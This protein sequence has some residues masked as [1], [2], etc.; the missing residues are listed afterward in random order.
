MSRAAAIESGLRPTPRGRAADQLI[1]LTAGSGGSGSVGG[2]APRS[3]ARTGSLRRS[4]RVRERERGFNNGPFSPVSASARSGTPPRL[5]FN[6]AMPTAA[7][8]ERSLRGDVNLDEALRHVD[9]KSFDLVAGLRRMTQLAEQSSAAGF[10]APLLAGLSDDLGHTETLLEVRRFLHADRVRSNRLEAPEE[11]WTAVREKVVRRHG[12]VR[13]AFA[14]M[15]AGRAGGVMSAEELHRGMMAMGTPHVTD[16]VLTAV[17]P[18]PKI[19]SSDIFLD[20]E[21]WMWVMD[22]CDQQ[23]PAP[24]IARKSVASS[25]VQAGDSLASLDADRE[26]DQQHAAT[27][28]DKDAQIRDLESEVALLRAAASAAAAAPRAAAAARPAAVEP[29]ETSVVRPNPPTA[30]L[31]R[32]WGSG[33]FGSAPPSPRQAPPSP[34]YKK[35][36]IF[37]FVLLLILFFVLFFWSLSLILLSLPRTQTPPTTLRSGSLRSSSPMALPS[38]KTPG[39]SPLRYTTPPKAVPHSASAH[40]ASANGHHSA[41]C[42]QKKT[43]CLLSSPPTTPTSTTPPHSNGPSPPPA[44]RTA[45]H[46]ACP[47]SPPPVPTIAARSRGAAAAASAASAPAASAPPRV[48]SCTRAAFPPAVPPSS[49]RPRA[50]RPA[51]QTPCTRRPR[52]AS[53][54]TTPLPLPPPPRSRTAPRRSSA[55]RRL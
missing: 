2:A 11:G 23:A 51:A 47:A 48:P 50:C 5:S 33:E 1:L 13:A 22:G 35:V 32:V 41:V 6:Y 9:W 31:M 54:A 27:L 14:N 42:A 20:F 29:L 3:P 30:H 43:C 4:E 37:V 44:S 46:P 26:R 17:C 53:A 36:L 12:S 8:K 15:C 40:S 18:D 10:V 16:R 45:S 7:S 21:E 19:P 25:E 34:S 55:R 52:P 24:T 39:N 49:P 38:V 28:R